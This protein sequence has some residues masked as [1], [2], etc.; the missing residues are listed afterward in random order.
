MLR[1]ISVLLLLG[2][3]SCVSATPPQQFPDNCRA[4]ASVAQLLAE[5]W[6]DQTGIWRLRQVTLLEVGHKKIPLEGFLRLDLAKGEARLVAMNEMGLVLF[7]LL[8]TEDD[9]QLQRAIP[10]LRQVKGLSLGIAQSLRWIFLQPRPQTDD[11]LTTRDNIQQLRRELPGG[12]LAFNYDCRRDL[13]NIRFLAD[14]GDWRVAYDQYRQFGSS[15]LPE[16]IIMNDFQHGVKL[17]LWIR[18]VKQ[19]R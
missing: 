6:L 18:E 9:Q 14:G 15:R 11:Q 8:V 5:N 13:R 7:D 12:S 10:Q 19:E 16:L 2:L 4:E 3:V 1:I 17:S